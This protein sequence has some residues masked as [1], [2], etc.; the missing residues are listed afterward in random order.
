MKMRKLINFILLLNFVS[1]TTSSDVVY[2]QD[3]ES[4]NTFNTKD[5]FLPHNIKVNDILKI[6]ISSNNYEASIN[7][8][9]VPLVPTNSSTETLQLEGYL[10][11]ENF[12]IN[13]PILGELNVMN[14][15]LSQLELLIKKILLE[16]NHLVQPNVTVRLINFKFT[17]LGEV[18]NPGTYSSFENKLTFFQALGFAG[19]L[20]IDAKRKDIT[21]IR[22]AN[23]VLKVSKIDLRK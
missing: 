10:V 12:T 19:D 16:D 13:F 1:C 20:T 11:S 23:G 14:M 21:L 6:D 15:T 18:A 8:N 3:L 5:W 22:E 17:V 2:L 9:K 4:S 7:Y